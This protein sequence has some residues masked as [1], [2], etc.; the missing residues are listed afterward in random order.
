V[1][2]ERMVATLSAAFALLATVLAAV[3]LYGVLAY[4]VTQRTREIG[5]RLALGATAAKLRGMVLKQVG[6]MAGIGVP[7]GLALA[8]L[9]GRAARTL[10]FGLSGYDPLV[11]T[12]AV[13][14]LVLVVSLAAYL[15]ARRAA[16][17]A[18]MEAL[19]SE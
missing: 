12:A 15:P 7:V 6:I 5:L 4:F 14:V 1:F 8:V 9:L 2:V 18:P 11:L 3:G 13:I 10:L 16:S 19:R 17:V